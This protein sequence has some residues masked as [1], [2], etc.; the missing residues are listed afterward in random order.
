[1]ARKFAAAVFCLG[2]SHSVDSLALG[3]GEITLDSFLNEPLKATVD[4]LDTEGLHA[5]GCGCTAGGRNSRDISW[6]L[7]ALG[8]LL[9]SR[10]RSVAD[11]TAP[12][13]TTVEPR[14][15]GR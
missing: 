2:A 5:D 6:L 8:L 13:R 12:G 9:W 10:R 4:L 14:D 1:M 3:L 11:N 7:A 15:F